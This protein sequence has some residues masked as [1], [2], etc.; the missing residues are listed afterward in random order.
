MLD[1][2]NPTEDS[3]EHRKKEKNVRRQL[4][5][6]QPFKPMTVLPKKAT[7]HQSDTSGVLQH[8]QFSYVCEYLCTSLKQIGSINLVDMVKGKERERKEDGKTV[9]QA[10]A[11]VR[12][13]NRRQPVSMGMGMGSGQKSLKAE[14]K[15]EA[16]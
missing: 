10:G 3:L 7:D 15:L 8:S 1:V 2:L 5:E 12:S 14:T 4:L 16:I 13:R 6:N 11:L 9:L